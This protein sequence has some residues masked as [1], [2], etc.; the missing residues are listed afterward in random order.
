MTKEKTTGA[1]AVRRCL[2]VLR[3]VGKST[4]SLTVAEIAQSLDLKKPTVHR[5]VAALVEEEFL[6]ANGSPQKLSL[7]AAFLELA[8]EAW[9]SLDIRG[10][11]APEL[12]RLAQ[13]TGFVARL[14]TLSG[15]RMVCVE[16][17]QIGDRRKALD[18]GSTESL[19]D[20]AAA[21]AIAAFSPSVS[22]T[23]K[24]SIALTK[25]RFYAIDNGQA[26]DG[27]RSVAA[28]VF[29]A[30]RD[31]V[32]AIAVSMPI[33]DG[34]EEIL[35]QIAPDVL[36]AAR[37]TSRATGGYPFAISPDTKASTGRDVGI[38]PLSQSE[39]LIG[40]SPTIRRESDEI[41]WIDI[42]GPKIFRR[43]SKDEV[44]EYPMPDVIGALLEDAEG[45]L[46]AAFTDSIAQ[47][48]PD[49][50]KLMGRTSV[51]GLSPNYRFNDGGFDVRGRLWLGSIDPALGGA[52]GRLL[53]V[54]PDGT[55]SAHVS[56]VGLPNGLV[57]DADG[58]SAFLVDSSLREIRRY[59]YDL[60]TGQFGD[61]AVIKRF[62]QDGP[63]PAGLCMTPAGTLYTAMWDGWEVL[64]FNDM[65][66]ELDRIAVPVPR[67]SGLTLADDGQRLILTSSRVRL[68]PAQLLNA[69]LSGSLFQLQM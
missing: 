31:A 19:A 17:A 38:S 65:G 43:T 15:D 12:E 52:T 69:P 59:D 64:E 42:L 32:A 13:A 33:R 37:N 54:D 21:Q 56:G 26:V 45:I 2:D 61:F 67:P 7:G 9:S 24:K 30:K 23:D 39:N 34:E 20:S 44:T 29:D 53:R 5:L 35:H 8:N 6:A 40:D 10:A 22:Y 46:W 16:S 66:D 25:A 49:T 68:T 47:F 4:N 14:M 50:G 48:M 27:W 62:D 36:Q 1:N 63:R 58:S 18:V 11:A 41:F 57:W 51:S 55:V 3:A 28:P 60:G